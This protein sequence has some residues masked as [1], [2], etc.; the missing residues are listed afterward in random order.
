MFKEVIIPGDFYNGDNFYI[1]YSDVIVLDL[2]ASVISANVGYGRH[3]GLYY[4]R[5]L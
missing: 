4:G 5:G 2:P 1:M 3:Y